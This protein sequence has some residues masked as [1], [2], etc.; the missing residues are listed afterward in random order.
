[1]IVSGGENVFATEVADVLA[2]HPD[3]ADSA[4][5]G[6]PDSDFGQRLRAFVQLHPDAVAPTFTEFST[7]LKSRLQRHKTP[8]EIVFLPEIPRN[9]AGKVERYR[10]HEYDQADL[11]FAVN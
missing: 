8:Q 7:F 9:P 4:V 2:L 3:V 10:L 1:M 5:I 11:V 6:V